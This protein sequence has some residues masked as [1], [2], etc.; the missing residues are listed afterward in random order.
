MKRF[1][2]FAVLIFVA[3]F[4][5]ACGGND[6]ES[7]DEQNNEPTELVIRGYGERPEVS[8]GERLRDAIGNFVEYFG[9]YRD[10]DN[11]D[12]NNSNSDMANIAEMLQVYFGEVTGL[13][14]GVAHL[15]YA[16]GQIH[17]VFMGD[18][19]F[20]S[21]QD[22]LRP[23]FLPAIAAVGAAIDALHEMGHV[24]RVDV[25][26]HSD[27]LPI[28]NAQFPSNWHLSN[29]RTLAIMLYLLDISVIDPANITSTGHGELLPIG[30]NAT[31]EG[32]Q[33]NRRIE[34]FITQKN[35]V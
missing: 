19:L 15:E 14:N 11:I 27:N 32:R 23:D 5:A 13:A 18:M 4:L 1:W 33:Q 34:I 25:V 22:V 35:D 24:I 30:D 10:A 6:T 7:N 12:E 29:E 8:I 28:F 31:A 26:G 9:T 16:E 3:V 21:G 2:V 17:L 20:E